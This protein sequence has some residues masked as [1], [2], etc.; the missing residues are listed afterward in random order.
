MHPTGSIRAL[1]FGRQDL[2][3]PKELALLA[4]KELALLGCPRLSGLFRMTVRTRW[5]TCRLVALTILST[6]TCLRARA[7]LG[8]ILRLLPTPINISLARPRRPQS[9]Q[10]PVTNLP[11]RCLPTSLGLGAPRTGSHRPRRGQAW[12]APHR[13]KLLMKVHTCGHLNRSDRTLRRVP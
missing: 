8:L 11:V 7:C 9:G 6:G 1:A 4:P 13:V 2:L 3:A 12:I 10:L 5:T